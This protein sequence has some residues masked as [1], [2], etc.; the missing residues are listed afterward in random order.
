MKKKMAVEEGVFEERKI[1][2]MVEWCWYGYDFE[3]DGGV[4]E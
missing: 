4:A 1:E 3:G 2:K